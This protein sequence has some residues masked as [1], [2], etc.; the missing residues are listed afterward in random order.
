MHR[1]AEICMS[2]AVGA[3]KAIDAHSANIFLA[4]CSSCCVI[5]IDAVQ[6]GLT[7]KNKSELRGK[8]SFSGYFYESLT[9]FSL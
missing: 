8:W 2:S 5:P 3:C 6:V 4:A 7:Y 1:A 9:L